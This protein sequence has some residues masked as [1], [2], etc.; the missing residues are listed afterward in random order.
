[1][2]ILSEGFAARVRG[3]RFVQ[4][5]RGATSIEYALIASL[6]FLVIVAGVTSAGDTLT[7]VFEKVGSEFRKAGRAE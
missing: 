1:M 6:I 2:S 7:A 3:Q 5:R 4:D